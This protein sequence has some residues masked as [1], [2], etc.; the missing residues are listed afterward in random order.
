MVETRSQ[1]HTKEFQRRAGE[2]DAGPAP[3][4]PRYHG[5]RMLAWTS[6]VIWV[7]E[8]YSSTETPIKFRGGNLNCCATTMMWPNAIA[9]V[10]EHVAKLFSV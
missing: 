4:R 6:S 2:I 7:N 9:C 5:P 3:I 1:S 10:N 8:L